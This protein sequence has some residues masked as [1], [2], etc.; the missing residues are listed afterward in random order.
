MTCSC[1]IAGLLSINYPGIISA[2]LS[3]GTEVALAL[4][5]TVLLGQTLNTLSISAYPFKPGQ[6]R[7]LGATCSSSANAEIKWI[8][9]YDCSS[10]TTYL[11][12][13]SGG[14]ASMSGSPLAGVYLDC[15][16]DVVSKAFN[17]SAQGG[18]SSPYILEYRRDGYNLRWTGDPIPIESASPV[19]YV[20]NLGIVNLTAYLQSF[21]LTVSPPSPATV[22]YN[23]VVPGRVQ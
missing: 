16:P 21:S 6:D 3:G 10:D 11:I 14:K 17:A 23:F 15:D 22:N 1:N 12:P 18:P 19:P 20:I 7:F 5:G 8:Q 2:S 13:Q 9:R 4:D